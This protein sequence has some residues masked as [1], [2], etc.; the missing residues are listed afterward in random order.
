VDF[1]RLNPW[2]KFIDYP[3][4]VGKELVDDIPYGVKWCS[5]LD[6]AKAYN[7]QLVIE[8][9]GCLTIRAPRSGLVRFKVFPLGISSAVALFQ[10]QMEALLG[11]DL[12]AAGVRVYLDDIL[13]FRP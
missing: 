8:K 12:I 4:P 6:M 5:H 3:L 10:R 11:E 9:H 2:L 13:I 1:R 7:K